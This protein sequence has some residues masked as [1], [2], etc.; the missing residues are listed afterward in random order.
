MAVLGTARGRPVFRTTRAAAPMD[1]GVGNAAPGRWS[2]APFRKRYS[3]ASLLQL[4]GRTAFYS[5]AFV[6]TGAS[7]RADVVHG[8]SFQINF[9]YKVF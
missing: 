8:K 7:L 6:L 5:V 4:T 9:E 2:F 3:A 1:I